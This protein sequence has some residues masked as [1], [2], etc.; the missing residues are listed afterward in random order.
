MDEAPARPEYSS[1]MTRVSV[2]FAATALPLVAGAEE[3]CD[4]RMVE[5]GLSSLEG[6]TEVDARVAMAAAVLTRSCPNTPRAFTRMP[7]LPPEQRTALDFSLVTQAADAWGTVCR[8]AEG[9]RIVSDLTALD[10]E[11]QRPHLWTACGLEA[12]GFMSESEWTTA[13][14]LRF[15]PFIG[16]QLLS[17]LPAGTQRTLVRALAGVQAPPAPS[18]EPASP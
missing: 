14:G 18:A 4:A 7:G 3:P 15:A 5:R 10:P 8:G 13:T 2:L 11:H 16:A 6:V 9:L 12:T 17:D 1:F